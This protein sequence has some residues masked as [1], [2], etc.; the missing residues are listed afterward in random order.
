MGSVTDLTIPTGS[1]V[2]VTCAN[3]YIA[4]HVV[5]QLL[6]AG[7]RVRGTV[8]NAKKGGWIVDFFEKKYGPGIIKLIEM[9]EMTEPGAFNEA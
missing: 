9:P 2:V 5:D 7:Y 6:Q 8:R 3:G 1:L 4:S